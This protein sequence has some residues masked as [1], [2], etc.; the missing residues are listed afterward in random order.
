M[1][2]LFSRPAARDL[3]VPVSAQFSI[4]LKISRIG[5]FEL[6]LDHRADDLERPLSKAAPIRGSRPDSFTQLTVQRQRMPTN[7]RDRLGAGFGLS[8]QPRQSFQFSAQVRFFTLN[9]TRDDTHHV[10]R[11]ARPE[12]AAAVSRRHNL[13]LEEK[14]DNFE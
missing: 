13:M 3:S 7:F 9:L 4:S 1:Y 5:H 14:R 12:L 6:V 11:H 2:G 8:Q 10:S